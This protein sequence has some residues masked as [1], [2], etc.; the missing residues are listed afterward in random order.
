[1]GFWSSLVNTINGVTKERK[2][3]V[4][5]LDNSGKTTILRKIK[6][7]KMDLTQVVPT[8]GCAVEEFYRN[9]IKFT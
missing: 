5:G 9:S 2:L 7:K 3:L 4:V 8:I 6:P 1:M